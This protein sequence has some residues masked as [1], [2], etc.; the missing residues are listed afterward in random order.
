MKHLYNISNGVLISSAT[1]IDKI[2]DGMSVKESDKT[3]VW[4]AETLDFDEVVQ[5]RILSRDDYL[6]L[7]TD[8]EM[9]AIVNAANTDQ[10]IKSSLD[11]LNF[12]DRV[13]MSSENTINSV[14][15]ME[16]QGL[17]SEGRASEVLNG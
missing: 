16:S 10:I 6:D 2:P 11:I 14:N 4:N 12:R 9:I 3:G 15:Y 1:T 7:F 17:I 13:R 5:D 8:S